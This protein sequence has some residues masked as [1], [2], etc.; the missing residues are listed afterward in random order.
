MPA[1]PPYLIPILGLLSAFGPMSI[2]MYLSALPAIAREFGVGTA[3][4]QAT[5]S[6]YFIGLALGQ[7][8]YGPLADRF[9]RKPPLYVGLV[10]YIAASV[11]V[12]RT[13]AIGDMI[14][15]RFLQAIGGCAGMVITRAIVRD[16]FDLQGSARVLSLLMLIMGVAPVLAPVAGSWLLAATGWRSIFWVL[17]IY[18]VICL[19]SV[20]AGLPESLSRH[21]VRPRMRDTFK[22]YLSLVRDRRFSGYAL[23]G[24]VAQAGMFAYISGSSFV[25]IDVYG[26]SPTAYAWIFGANSFG[27][28]SAYQIN[29]YLLHR[30]SP[31]RLLA[32]GN[33]VNGSA[34]VLLLLSGGTGIGGMIGFAIL[35]F[36]TISSLGFTFA[37]A[38]ASAMAAFPDRAGSASALLGTFQFGM[39]AIAGTAV[40]RF[41]DGTPVP[42]AVVICLCGLGGLAA[43]RFVVPRCRGGLRRAD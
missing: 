16:H 15:W 22:V 41:H 27:L 29:R 7:G 4:A 36:L 17:A 14:A 38:A 10:I 11:G 35:L 9:G 28:V 33:A 21:A 12:A 34:G 18:G 42:M 20:A 26:L 6:I 23:A 19:L 32:L 39:A 37:N 1:T 43:Q 31:A 5:L 2:D 40:G 30:R 3:A 8:I 24:A 13:G 25:F